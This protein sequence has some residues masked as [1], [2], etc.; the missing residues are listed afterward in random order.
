MKSKEL[1]AL[2]VL[3]STGID[4]LEAA[5]V[6]KA[7]LE[8]GGTRASEA[9]A[10]RV[11]KYESAHTGKLFPEGMLFPICRKPC[12]SKVNTLC[13]IGM[14]HLFNTLMPMRCR[15]HATKQMATNKENTCYSARG[16]NKLRFSGRLRCH[17]FA[18]FRRKEV[19]PQF[20]FRIRRK[21]RLEILHK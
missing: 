18:N 20:I 11:L 9:T 8:A 2:G 5:L 7:A 13:S 16:E 4:I 17:P 14:K 19:I 21:M 1:A 3:L 6:A 15:S 12:F 10:R